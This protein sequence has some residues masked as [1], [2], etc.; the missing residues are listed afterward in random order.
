MRHHDREVIKR[1]DLTELNVENAMTIKNVVIGII[2]IGLVPLMNGAY[3]IYKD[4]AP[5]REKR[6]MF[7]LKKYEIK[8]KYKR[9]IT[10]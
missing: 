10:Q 4:N 2:T 9:G 1:M 8:M 7:R 6:R 5:E 3:K